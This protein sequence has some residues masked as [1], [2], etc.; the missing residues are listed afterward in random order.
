ML[1]FFFAFVLTLYRADDTINSIG[2]PNT[3]VDNKY[4]MSTTRG[5]DRLKMQG[6]LQNRVTGTF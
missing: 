5:G 4:I 2:V 6:I 1:C 3:W